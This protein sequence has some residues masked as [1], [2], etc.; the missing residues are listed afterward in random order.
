MR[1][2]P[3]RH[4]HRFSVFLDGIDLFDA[5]AFST[6]ENEAVLMDPQQRLLLEAAAEALL[7][8]GAVGGAACDAGGELARLV[9]GAGV[10]VGITSTEYAQLAQVG[11]WCEQQPQGGARGEGAVGR[12]SSWKEGRI[13]ARGRA[14]YSSQPVHSCTH[15]HPAPTFATFPP[16][17]PRARLHPLLRHRQPHRQRGA[18]PPVLHLGPEGPLPARGHR[19]LFLPRQARPVLRGHACWHRCHAAGRHYN[20]PT[21]WD[22]PTLTRAALF[23]SRTG[24]TPRL[25]CSL[26]IAFSSVALGQ[27]TSAVNAGVNLL[28]TPNTTAMTQKAGMLALDGRCKTLSPAADGYARADACGVMLL[29]PAAAVGG[30]GGASLAVLAGTAVNQ[31]GRS[32]TLTAPN[33]PA[34]QAVVRTALAAGGQEPAAV[35]ALQMHG[36]GEGCCGHLSMHSTD[37]QLLRNF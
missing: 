36:T 7:A 37:L 10:F 5:A 3:P 11:G 28:L 14:R 1:A 29:L 19:L 21:S 13:N 20:L 12:S 26:H 34:Q 24:C 4:L 18:R 22:C 16:A 2:V 33:G 27:C 17:A 8:A 6:S 25:R 35:S 31:D 9:S 15:T 32:S 30:S 23:H